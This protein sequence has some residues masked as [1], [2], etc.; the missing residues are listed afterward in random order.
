MRA[1]MVSAGE[2]RHVRLRAKWCSSTLQDTTFVAFMKP[3]ATGDVSSMSKRA[4]PL[5]GG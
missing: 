2:L 5:W 3:C 1:A 4:R